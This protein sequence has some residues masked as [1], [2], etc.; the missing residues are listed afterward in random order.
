MQEWGS[1]IQTEAW[2]DK[3][4]HLSQ[5][6]EPRWKWNEIYGEALL[7][8]YEVIYRDSIAFSRNSWNFEIDD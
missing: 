4:G 5:P 3:I 8:M 1:S 6:R 2:V 7:Q